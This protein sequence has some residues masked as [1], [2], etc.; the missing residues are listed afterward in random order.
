MRNPGK[1]NTL[2]DKQVSGE[3]ILM[4]VVTMHRALALLL[5][6]AFERDSQTLVRFLA[7]GRIGQDDVAVAVQSHSVIR[8]WQILRSEPEIQ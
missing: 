6:Q 2:T 3:Q 7:I 4:A 8:V 5:H 1:G